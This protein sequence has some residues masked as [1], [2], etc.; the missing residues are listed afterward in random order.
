MYAALEPEMLKENSVVLLAEDRRYTESKAIVKVLS[1]LPGLYGAL[2]SALS[3]VPSLVSDFVY[4]IVAKIRYRLF[5]RYSTCPMLSDEVL[6]R[7]YRETSR[8]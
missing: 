8:G 1:I 3:L 6:K 5:G 4:R 2:G 7:E